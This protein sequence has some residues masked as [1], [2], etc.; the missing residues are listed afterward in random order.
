M[1]HGIDLEL[2]PVPVLPVD[3]AEAKGNPGVAVEA[4]P[5]PDLAEDTT[6]RD[7][8]EQWTELR[9][10]GEKFVERADALSHR[11][12]WKFMDT[13]ARLE[14]KS[15]TDTTRSLIAV[16]ALGKDLQGYPPTVGGH[17]DVA[18]ITLR[19]GFKWESDQ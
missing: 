15:L 11:N 16:E 18:T 12:Y 4:A 7:A 6:D 2:G 19:D 14:M 1:A 5:Y 17:I 9:Q 13:I 8:I 3:E 10:L